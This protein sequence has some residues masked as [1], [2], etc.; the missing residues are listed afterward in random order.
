MA[1]GCWRRKDPP[2][3]PSTSVA[4]KCN[5]NRRV[6]FA[7]VAVRTCCSSELGGSTRPPPRAWGP[8]TLRNQERDHH[9]GARLKSSGH[10]PPRGMAYHVSTEDS[11]QSRS[12]T[13]NYVSFQVSTQYDVRGPP[14]ANG[15]APYGYVIHF[16]FCGITGI[17]NS[18][19]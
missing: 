13:T 17:H 19:T 4:E 1:R 18:S 11:N 6:R 3:L 14:Q 10:E 12:Y 9:V 8:Q 16:R 7:F 15:R 2:L 5:D